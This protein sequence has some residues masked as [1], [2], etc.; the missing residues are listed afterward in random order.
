MA[1]SLATR[2]ASLQLLHVGQIEVAD[3]EVSDPAVMAQFR[4]P[5]QRLLQRYRAA[6]MQQIQI[7]AV[8]PQATQ[9]ALASLRNAACASHCGDRSS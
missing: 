4:E 2:T 9:A 8:G 7:D 1:C 5:F 6:P 3:A